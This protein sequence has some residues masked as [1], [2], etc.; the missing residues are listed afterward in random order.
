MS[1]QPADLSPFQVRLA[2]YAEL[3][4]QR[5][6]REAEVEN[7]M[8]EMKQLEAELLPQFEQLGMQSSK[9][10]GV[11]IYIAREL[12]ASALDGDHDKANKALEEAG[13]GNLILPRFNVQTL[14]AYVRELD[15]AGEELPPSFDGAIKVAE[16]FKLKSRG[17]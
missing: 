15:K 8:E 2:R 4:K 12:W 1:T 10:A 14:S 6:L 9:V 13:L 5:K 11:T 17:R 3:S 16:V 7:I